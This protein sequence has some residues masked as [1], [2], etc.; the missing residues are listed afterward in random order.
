MKRTIGVF[1]PRADINDKPPFSEP[2]FGIQTSLCQRIVRENQSLDVTFVFFTLAHWQ[3]GSLEIDALTFDGESWHALHTPIPPVVYDRYFSPKGKAKAAKAFR[4]FLKENGVVFTTPHE[5]TR[6]TINKRKFNRFL[7][8]NAIPCLR[9]IAFKDLSEESLQS[10]LRKSGTL[11]LKPITGMKG[12]GIAVVEKIASHRYLLHLSSEEVLT[13]ET[14]CLLETLKETGRFK[15][16]IAQVN[17][18]AHPFESS[19]FFIRVLV[20]NVCDGKYSVTGMLARVGAQKAWTAI[21]GQG[22]RAIPLA[23]LETY[24]R[25]TYQKNIFEE[26]D[27]IERMCLQCCYHLHEEFGDFAE[28]AFDVILTREHG[29]AILEANSKPGRAIF[30]LIVRTYPE[31]SQAR[32][33]YQAVVSESLQKLGKF[34]LYRL[35]Q[36]EARQKLLCATI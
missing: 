15:R 29:P 17:A 36:V 18:N 33:Y 27:N 20:Q 28:L 16:Y 23:D 31:G 22:E 12:M 14:D 6:L 4:S 24:Y 32:A 21:P 11:Y 13:L 7:E 19:P 2:P 3:P 35:N 25:D 1:I 34:A 8:K 30:K 5:L 26:R 9:T 10:M